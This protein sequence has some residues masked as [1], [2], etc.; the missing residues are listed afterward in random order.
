MARL[1]LLQE[2]ASR[3]VQQISG[4]DIQIEFRNNVLF[5]AAG[6]NKICIDM[7][8]LVQ[9]KEVNEKFVRMETRAGRVLEI[10]SDSANEISEIIGKID[11][12]LAAR[13]SEYAIRTNSSENLLD[14]LSKLTG[15]AKVKIEVEK[16]VNFARYQ[17]R[18]QNKGGSLDSVSRHMVFTGN[19]GTG[20]TT[21]A[22]IIAS[23]YKQVGILQKGQFVEVD[24]AS[25]VGG[26]LGQTAIKTNELID[27]AIGGILFIDEAYSLSS[28]RSQDQ[29][30]EEA[31]NI[32]LKRMEDERDNL[33]VI[34]AG[35]QEEMDEFINSNPGL[36][37]R[38]SKYVHFEDYS[39]N[40]LSQIFGDLI[41]KSGHSLSSES[42]D[43]LKFIFETMDA[44]KDDKFGNGRTVRN[45]YE[46]TIE[47]L[48]NRVANGEPSQDLF[49][50]LPCDITVDD[51][52]FI[53]GKR[54]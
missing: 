6:G 5:F 29:F 41:C 36:R 54:R 16:I 11:K 38:F 1:L 40:E 48:A 7:S 30:G 28:G 27:Q 22:R 12:I 2:G 45:L 35:Y 8:S 14:D 31:I 9:S 13:N 52:N 53:M 4:I 47:N 17:N 23:I 34:V 19:P 43:R 24:R 18:I 3:A 21:V 10:H 37:S 50:I 46:R 51:L 15:L 44:M 32:L 49:T 33:V 26:Y 39:A 42:K 25:L 20:K